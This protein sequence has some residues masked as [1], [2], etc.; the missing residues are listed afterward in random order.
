MTQAG[1]APLAGIT[2]LAAFDA[3]AP[4]QEEKVLVVGAA[5]GVGSFFVQLAANVGAHVIS[6]ALAEDTEHL[7]EL[8]VDE[9]LDRNADL[10][11][12]VRKRHPDDVDAILDVVSFAPQ[13]SLLAEGGRL[14]SP[15]GAAGEGRGRFNARPTPENLQ[16][17]AE[18]QGEARGALP[19]RRSRGSRSRSRRG[20]DRS[21]TARRCR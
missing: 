4:E 6:P 16:R 14:A 21:R 2:A 20:R 9:T 8:G 7:R 5:G 13:D 12:A 15:L 19:R 18:P 11:T 10:E 17:L 3:L 1:A